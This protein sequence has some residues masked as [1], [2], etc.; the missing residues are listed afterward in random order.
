MTESLNNQV[1]SNPTNLRIETSLS[2]IHKKAISD[3][4]LGRALARKVDSISSELVLTVPYQ[5]PDK[6]GDGVLRLLLVLIKAARKLG[7]KAFKW[8]NRVNKEQFSNVIIMWATIIQKQL[9]HKSRGN[10]RWPRAKHMKNGGLNPRNL[11]LVYHT[12]DFLG[13]F[14]A[15]YLDNLLKTLNAILSSSQQSQRILRYMSCASPHIHGGSWVMMKKSRSAL[16]R[17]RNRT[18]SDVRLSMNL[19]SGM[20][21]HVVQDYATKS[22][23]DLYQTENAA[24]YWK[25]LHNID[26]WRLVSR[27]L[28]NQYKRHGLKYDK[29]NL[30]R[31]SKGKRTL[32]VEQT[33][34]FWDI[35]TIAKM[36]M[37]MDQG[38]EPIQLV[39]GLWH[40]SNLGMYPSARVVDA[41]LQAAYQT[42]VGID[43]DEEV[44]QTVQQIR[45]S[46]RR[47][48]VSVLEYF[49]LDGISAKNLYILG[50]TLS[51]ENNELVQQKFNKL[52]K[53]GYGHQ[54]LKNYRSLLQYGFKVN[55]HR[56]TI[57]N[58]LKKYLKVIINHKNPREVKDR[59]VYLYYY[60]KMAC[61]ICE[62]PITV[63]FAYAGISEHILF[64]R[65]RLESKRQKADNFLRRCKRKGAFE[66]SRGRYK[67]QRTGRLKNL[68]SYQI[69]RATEVT[70]VVRTPNAE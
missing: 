52:W 12:I 9:L 2:A 56:L 25:L 35:S 65:N 5:K 45:G 14:D 61:N 33:R 48:S 68:K 23:L 38:V 67:R 8:F 27:C 15:W 50:P 62:L 55:L 6:I 10:F 11:A 30:F 36:Q 59:A 39:R 20:L 7:I 26:R 3:D 24:M 46:R 63:I 44:G 34:Q 70:L 53:V 18:F 4:M 29:V 58:H 51:T 22:L 19:N 37:W 43:G 28:P 1:K 54:K 41:F 69:T 31:L 47:K 32:V 40:L 17:K 57:K 49:L 13:T 21:D 64:A 16:K 60:L 42:D 66:I